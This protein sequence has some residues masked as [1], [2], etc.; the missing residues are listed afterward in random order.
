MARWVAL[1]RGI[2]V[3]KHRRIPMADLKE[4]LAGLGYEDV[5]TVGISGNVTLTAPGKA[6]D[7]EAAIERVVEERCGVDGVL[8]VVRSRDELAKVVGDVPWPERTGEGKFLHVT[9]L[10]AEPDADAKAK[11]EAAV[12]GGDE[13][14]WAGRE[15]Y[16]WF[17]GGMQGS[18]V[19]K[20]LNDKALG[21]TATDRNWNTVTKLLE[22]AGP[23]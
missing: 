5:S 9:F 23:E 1:L 8:V 7:V 19:A 11:V 17:E 6:K 20:V 10:S 22:L 4:A 16:V 15:V 18:A 2:N 14:A 13:V 3:G 21:V 12:D